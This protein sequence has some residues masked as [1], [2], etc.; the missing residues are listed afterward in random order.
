MAKRI[1]YEV[2]WRTTW[3]AKQKII[4]ADLFF[5]TKFHTETL[6]YW[7]SC[8]SK[9]HNKTTELNRN[10][11]FLPQI[12]HRISGNWINL[13]KLTLEVC[14]SRSEL[15]RPTMLIIYPILCIKSKENKMKNISVRR[16][17][18]NEANHKLPNLGKYLFYTYFNYTESYIIYLTKHYDSKFLIPCKNYYWFFTESYLTKFYDEA[19]V[20]PDDDDDVWSK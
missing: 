11:L 10:R 3:S 19:H 4:N 17:D 9:L 6:S 16:K 1:H 8:K 18:W 13:T 20:V 14:V 5:H 2:K 15:K 12:F 7:V